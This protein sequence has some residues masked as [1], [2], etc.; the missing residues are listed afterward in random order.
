MTAIFS[1]D[2]DG[3]SYDVVIVGAGSAGCALAARL[4]Q[5]PACRVL[6]L[7]AGPD[8][9][10]LDAQPQALKDPTGR[11]THDGPHSWAY[12]AEHSGP[13]TPL[14]AWRGRLVGGSGGVNGG[15]YVR[16]V[17]ED[18]DAWGSRLWDFDHVLPCFVRSE[19]DRDFIGSLHG[20]DGPV[21]VGRQA[22]GAWT[23]VSA[24]FGEAAA[25]LGFPEKPDLNASDGSG[26]GPVPRNNPDGFRVSAA[27]SYLTAARI[28]PNLTIV[29]GATVTR[30]LL[31][32]GNA[33]GVEMLRA[34]RI[35]SVRAGHVVLCAGGIAS[36]QLLML[37]GIGDADALRRLG[38]EPRMHLP[39]VGAN[40]SD[41]PWLIVSSRAVESVAPRADERNLQ[42][43]LTWTA[44]NSPY[45]N[46][47]FL[48]TDN[49]V[50]SACFGLFTQLQFP[51]SRG[52]IM[53]RSADPTVGPLIR[54]RYYSEPSDL[55]R[56]RQSVR[57]S[58]QFLAH[59]AM[60]AITRGRV[61]PIDADLVDDRSLDR[62]I[63]ANSGTNQHSSGTC[64]M[65]PEGAEGTVVD[66][67]CAVVGTRNLFVA[68]LSICPAVVRAGTNATA[69]MIGERASDLIAT[70]IG[71]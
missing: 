17:R 29:S 38:I 58:L 39:G 54:Y 36:P 25:A 51:L 69:V 14:T 2:P 37:S 67:H 10:D 18:Y 45:R 9:P 27:Y 61:S 59:P 13:D 8:Y 40:L 49:Q 35:E 48:G 71:L 20:R 62:W 6:L 7:E 47:M 56:M 31:D 55:E 28:R 64:R 11:A 22:P 5:R 19:T 16:G 23:P 24:A 50:A 60:R 32:K 15:L 70:R 30:V 21:A 42:V 57:L 44:A 3:R 53:L 68:D 26:W 65:G 12:E 52:G 34:G 33:T 43:A 63:I 66:D 4:S 46:D 41:H 1:S